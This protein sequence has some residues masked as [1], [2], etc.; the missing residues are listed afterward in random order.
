MVRRI[1]HLI[2]LIAALL[3]V[4]TFLPF[5]VQAQD[6]GVSPA[7]VEVDNLSPGEEAEFNLIIYNKDDVNHTYKLT[8]YKPTESERRQG[9]TKFPDD[10]WVSF[11]QQVEVQAKSTKVVKVKVIIP[12]NQKWAGEDWEIWLGAVTESS[13]LL[14]VQ[15]CVRLLI[16]TSEEVETS[17]NKWQIVGIT[18]GIVLL[19]F[20]I[21]RLRKGAKALKV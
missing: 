9:R 8:T 3:L 17:S 21:Y 13:D 6:F 18:A 16:S 4:A 11:P 5:P 15:L 7:E 19:I 1:K 2:G 12:S 20:G 10:S 14:A